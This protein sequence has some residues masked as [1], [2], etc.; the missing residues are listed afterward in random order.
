MSAFSHTGSIPPQ[1]IWE[2]V[3]SRPV[4]G[5]QMTLSL[6]EL[7]PNAGVPAELL[8]ESDDGTDYAAAAALSPNVRVGRTGLVRSGVGAARSRA[9]ARAAAPFVTYVDADDVVSPDYLPL[10]LKAAGGRGA[11]AVTRVVE[12]GAELARF[13]TPGGVLDFAELARHGASFRGLF[14]RA[15][16]PDF[17]NDLSQD[18]LHMAEV[19]L[20]SGPIPMTGAVYTLNLAEGTVTA[21]DDFSARVD[22]AYGRHMQRLGQGYAGHEDLA[23]AQAVFEAKRNL[24]RRYVEEA[25]PGE[26]YYGFIARV[27]P[28]GK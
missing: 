4:H 23:K 20:R 12:N 27:E 13:G 25:L 7:A 14:P 19:L 5:E 17:E 18:I 2:G 28:L 21:A 8:V 10:L 24:N 1:Q 26:S 6:I 22:A 11:A 3:T 15:L 16:M 9:L